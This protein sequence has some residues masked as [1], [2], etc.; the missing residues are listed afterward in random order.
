MLFV[1]KK[2]RALVFSVHSDQGNSFTHI[3]GVSFIYDVIDQLISFYKQEVESIL[4][5]YQDD[6]YITTFVSTQESYQL[7]TDTEFK[8][9]DVLYL[10]ELPALTIADTLLDDLE[11]NLHDI[12]KWMYSHGDDADS[13]DEL[14]D[15]L[16]LA[17]KKIRDYQMLYNKRTTE[18]LPL[19]EM[20]SEYIERE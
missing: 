15:F 16:I 8:T 12:V 2:N 17:I 19:V 20:F 5:R 3:E 18:I 10:G 13:I 14:Y 6:R 1:S 7:F 11:A 4:L 9:V